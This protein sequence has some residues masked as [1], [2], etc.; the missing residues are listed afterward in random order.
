M[1]GA[2]PVCVPPKRLP[3][4]TARTRGSG[5]RTPMVSLVYP[6]AAPTN[7]RACANASRAASRSPRSSNARPTAQLRVGSLPPAD[8][9]VVLGSVCATRSPRTRECRLQWLSRSPR[10]DDWPIGCRVGPSGREAPGHRRRPTL[11]QRRRGTSEAPRRANAMATPGRHPER[12]LVATWN[13]S[14][15]G[16][17]PRGRA[18]REHR[19]SRLVAVGWAM[20]RPRA[21]SLR[22]PDEYRRWPPRLWRMLRAQRP[23]MP[24]RWAPTNRRR[25]GRRGISLGL[26]P[27]RRDGSWRIRAV[28]DCAGSRPARLRWPTP[29]LRILRSRLR[30]ALRSLERSGP[31]RWRALAVSFGSREAGRQI[32]TVGIS[33][34]GCGSFMSEADLGATVIA[35]H[36]PAFHGGPLALVDN[37]S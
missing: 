32:D 28:V 5:I 22:C 14:G 36:D 20:V 12:L 19:R 3:V 1:L 9:R 13:S 10:L 4:S 16:T 34:L 2:S 35:R 23:S 11:P 15:G 26:G 27:A 8:P 37:S 29:S 25:G 31:T 18:G 6:A 21:A 30:Q 7:W 33:R 24:R 17:T